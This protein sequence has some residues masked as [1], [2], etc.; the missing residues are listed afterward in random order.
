MWLSKKKIFY[1]FNWAMKKLTPFCKQDFQMHFL[2]CKVLCI[3][4]NFTEGHSYGSNWQKSA[5]LKWCLTHWGWVMQICVSKLA[6]IDSDNGL[7]HDQAII[8]TSAGIL[9]IG[10]L[11]A[12]FSEILIEIHA[13]SFRKMQLKMPQWQLYKPLP[14]P[15]LTKMSGG[16]H[17]QWASLE[18]H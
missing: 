15:V 5:L 3:N 9:L 2:K 14:E 4:S 10:P 11:G 13:S 1:S 7:S 17:N 16:M 8:W 6:I 12:K 18:P